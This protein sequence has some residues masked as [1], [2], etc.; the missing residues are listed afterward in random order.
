MVAGNTDITF[1]FPSSRTASLY[2]ETKGLDLSFDP[3]GL[4]YE[5][6]W[7]VNIADDPISHWFPDLGYWSCSTRSA[8]AAAD[9][10]STALYLTAT[11]TSTESE[12]GAHVPSYSRSTPSPDEETASIHELHPLETAASSTSDGIPT[13]PKPNA[14]EVGNKLAEQMHQKESSPK[15]GPEAS[16]VA[17]APGSDGLRTRPASTNTAPSHLQAENF[18]SA[19]EVKEAATALAEIAVSSTNE[20]GGIVG[21]IAQS[22]AVVIASTNALG[23]S[24]DVLPLIKVSTTLSDGMTPIILNSHTISPEVKSQYLISGQT[25]AP[26]SPM[27]PSSDAATTEIVLHTSNSHTVLIVGSFTSTILASPT[28]LQTLMIGKQIIS[29]DTQGRYIVQDQALVPDVLVTL[30]PGTVATPILLQTSMSDTILSGGSSFSSGLAAATG[31][32]SFTVGA[33]VVSANDEGQYIVDS[34]TLT[35]GIPITLGSGTAATPILLQTTSSN[36][37]LVVGSSTSTIF[38]AATGAQAI[39]IGDQIVSANTQNQFIIGSETLTAG[40][41]VTVSGTPV[42]L[43]PSATKVAVG[44]STQELG[45]Y[46]VS[47]LG[48]G[49]SAHSSGAVAFE[50]SGDRCQTWARSGILVVIIIMVMAVVI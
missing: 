1:A 41:V 48:G 44:T 25:L 15:P 7:D 16:V 35:P 17:T 36:T 26:G 37:I 18:H 42:S 32:Q 8:V 10:H 29:V 6:A 21:S 14:A 2:T 50:G 19:V 12:H 20:H 45:G 23:S 28:V 3:K 40:G 13:A 5:P 33:Q 9:T 43:A 47:G 34:R 4:T 11:S 49:P 46:I 30:S 27:T 31:P 22:P 39:T 24:S 38:A